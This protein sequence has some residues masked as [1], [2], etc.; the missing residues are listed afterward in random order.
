MTLKPRLKRYLISSALMI[1]GMFFTLNF[2]AMGCVIDLSEQLRFAFGAFIY[3]M[4]TLV[5][6]ASD[7]FQMNKA[8]RQLPLFLLLN[9]PCVIIAYGIK[10]LYILGAYF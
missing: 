4:G 9:I 1:I 3:V 10:S 6:L 8:L 5:F 2:F 7:N